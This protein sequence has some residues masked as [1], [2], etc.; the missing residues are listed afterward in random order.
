M[1]QTEEGTDVTT[2][3]RAREAAG[4]APDRPRRTEL[5]IR[6]DDRIAKVKSMLPAFQDA[7]RDEATAKRLIR[8][9]ITIVR[10]TPKIVECTQPSFLGALMT[11]AQL[12]LRPNVG[13]LG[14]C[15]VLPFEDKRNRRVLAQFV[16]G[17][18]GMITL[19]GRSGLSIDADTVYSNEEFRISR[20]TYR[21]IYHVPILEIAKRGDPIAHYAFARWGTGEVWK[22]IGHDEAL[23]ARDHSPAFKMKTGPWMDDASNGWPMCRKTAVRR[24]FAYIP[25][26]SPELAAAVDRIIST[27][28]T[29]Q[30]LDQATME[31]TAE[32]VADETEPSSYADEQPAREVID[33]QPGK[34]AKAQPRRRTPGTTATMCQFCGQNRTLTTGSYF[35]A[36]G[37]NHDGSVDPC[38]GGGQ[39][40]EQVAD[41]F[42]AMKAEAA[43]QAAEA[44]DAKAP[45]TDPDFRP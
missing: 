12:D 18:R 29:V 8:D 6:Q 25:T 45:P 2:S 33:V 41:T 27:D 39:T 35:V 24:L 30:N 38:P 21:E 4:I 23:Q 26:D 20:G 16:L 10:T 3:N 1:G 7:L 34:P 17:Y 28:E 42:E 32:E 31:T 40:P 11:A 13:S 44:A 36:H 5:E 15:W 43:A 19:G 9:A 37:M 22:A 14:H